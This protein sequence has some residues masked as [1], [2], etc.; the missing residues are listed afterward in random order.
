V[1]M[2]EI[3]KVGERRLNMMRA[4]NAREGFSRDDDFLPKKFSVPLKGTGPSSGV[5]VPADK[6]E[7]WK[8][9]YYEM[10]GWDR[11]KGNPTAEKLDE[12]GLS[13]VNI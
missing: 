11:E 13:W 1:T 4:F 12:L 10:A 3:L 8:D 7:T 9:L 5:T 6:L 2:D